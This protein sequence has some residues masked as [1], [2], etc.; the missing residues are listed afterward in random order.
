MASFGGGCH[1]A[2]NPDR[3]QSASNSLSIANGIRLFKAPKNN[4]DLSQRDRSCRSPH[5]QGTLIGNGTS[6]LETPH[7]TPI[8]GQKCQT[9]FD[10]LGRLN[11]INDLGRPSQTDFIVCIQSLSANKEV[12]PPTI[13]PVTKHESRSEPLSILK[14]EAG[15]HGW[16]AVDRGVILEGG[17]RGW[18]RSLMDRRQQLQIRKK[19]CR[20]ISRRA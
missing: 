12:C 3:Q 11:E 19:R 4:T 20:S 8:S 2:A 16:H 15:T 14:I 10:R 5:P 13:N 17:R 6:A 7:L 18:N 9:D 1:W